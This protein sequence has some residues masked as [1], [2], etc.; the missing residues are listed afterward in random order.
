M[1]YQALMF[2]AGNLNHPGITDTRKHIVVDPQM[3]ALAHT[4]TE[5]QTDS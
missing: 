1:E 3:R 2:H 5:K 4:H